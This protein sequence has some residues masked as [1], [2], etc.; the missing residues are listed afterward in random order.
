MLPAHNRLVTPHRS[1]DCTRKSLICTGGYSATLVFESEPGDD[2]CAVLEGQRGNLLYQM[3]RCD[4][5]DK[6]AFVV[7]VGRRFLREALKVIEE[8]EVWLACQRI[9]HHPFKPYVAAHGGMYHALVS[10]RADPKVSTIRSSNYSSP[11]L[12]F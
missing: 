9:G 1:R 5:P 12:L 6:Q 7:A 8:S 10:S 3:M 11:K 4:T 2:D